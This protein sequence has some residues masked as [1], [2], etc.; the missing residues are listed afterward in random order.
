MPPRRVRRRS[1]PSTAAG[2]PDAIVRS[3]ARDALQFA[4][5][6]GPATRGAV[7]SNGGRPRRRSAFHHVAPI[8]QDH[9]DRGGAGRRRARA[10]RRRGRRPGPTGGRRPRPPSS[11]SRSAAGGGA[12][13]PP[14]PGSRRGR[15]RGHRGRRRRPGPSVAV[16][17]GPGEAAPGPIVRAVPVSKDWMVLSYMPDWNFGNV[18]NIGIGNRRRQ[19]H[20]DRVAPR[21]PPRR[22]TD[23]DR[24]FLLAIYARQTVSNPPAGPIVACEVLEKWNEQTSWKT[25]PR[26]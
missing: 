15:G 5:S 11:S 1:A 20:A 14:A 19:P 8:A 4:R 13:R 10:H 25:R 22:P 7:A 3:V 24:R 23:P 9:H 2:L 16:R 26:Y 6:A 21:S 17:P 18:N 12:G